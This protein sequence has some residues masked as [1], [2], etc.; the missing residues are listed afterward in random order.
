M[1]PGLYP[2]A[3]VSLILGHLTKTAAGECSLGSGVGGMGGSVRESRRCLPSFLVV[4][5]GLCGGCWLA[6]CP[7][8]YVGGPGMVRLC[9]CVCMYV[10]LYFDVKRIDVTR[11]LAGY[12]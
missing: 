9:V 7:L 6:G 4:T 8:P 11:L 1:P 3:T 10:G 12:T 2:L 5:L